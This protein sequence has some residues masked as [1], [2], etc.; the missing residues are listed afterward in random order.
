MIVA[1]GE[2]LTVGF[3]ERHPQDRT[4]V[5]EHGSEPPTAGALSTH[6]Y[7]ASKVVA[8]LILLTLMVVW[9]VLFRP[10]VLGGPV[11]YAEVM[12]RS[13]APAVAMGDV[14]AAHPRS[15]YRV[16]ELIVYRAPTARPGAV[17]LTV[18]R[19]ANGS[20]TSG[21]AVDYANSLR[22]SSYHLRSAEIVGSVWFHF[23]RT[24]LL[25]WC[26]STATVLVILVNIA[27]PAKRLLRRPHLSVTQR[28]SVAAGDPP[29]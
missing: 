13:I 10:Q 5:E 22:P 15:S 26:V 24:L 23:P 9:I 8:R 11:V 25:A 18:G 14:V 27:L 3:V 4:V 16:G 2:A 19:I 21:Y 12:D 17:K 7:H 20:D 6:R 1:P 28:R 29:T